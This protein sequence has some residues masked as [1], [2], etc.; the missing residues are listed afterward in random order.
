MEKN[1]AR[2]PNGL[3]WGG[4]GFR[5][6]RSVSGRWWISIGLPFGFRYTRVLSNR[7]RA[8]P[9]EQPESD[10]TSQDSLN[11]NQP[12]ISDVGDVGGDRLQAAR[13]APSKIAN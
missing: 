1:S 7:Q 12:S 2:F 6:G 4:R 3:S 5:I 13:R 11:L 9:S 8:V 10:R